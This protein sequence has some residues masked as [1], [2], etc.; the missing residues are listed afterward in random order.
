MAKI[1][2]IM[3]DVTLITVACHPVLL[4]VLP[5]GPDLLSLLARVRLVALAQVLAHRGAVLRDLPAVL[6][7]VALLLVARAP[8]L[9]QVTTIVH[10]VAAV[11]SQ[12]APVLLRVAL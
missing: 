7:D 2:A 1:A 4:D 8:I 5:F 12:V 10:A 9:G 11:M 3:V 6:I